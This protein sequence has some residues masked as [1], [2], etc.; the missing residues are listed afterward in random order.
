MA[1][2]LQKVFPGKKVVFENEIVKNKAAIEAAYEEVAMMC[3][4]GNLNIEESK[5][6]KIKPKK[7]EIDTAKIKDILA[8]LNED[9]NVMVDAD[10]CQL[11]NMELIP[12][13]PPN[14]A[15]P[16]NS[17]QRYKKCCAGS[18]ALRNKQSIAMIEDYLKNGPPSKES[19]GII[20]I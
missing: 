17:K 5:E 2:A 16:C 19:K 12:M 3:S 18:D 1:Q 6:Q 11:H 13:P 15:C 7:D 10:N 14:R 4:F 8:Q 20:F 9:K